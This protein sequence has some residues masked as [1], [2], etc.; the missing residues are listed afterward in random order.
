MAQKWPDDVPTVVMGTRW[1]ALT[2]GHLDSPILIET[3][4]LT[5]LTNR[6]IVAPHGPNHRS[7]PARHSPARALCRAPPRL[8]DRA[9]LIKPHWQGW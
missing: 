8:D 2:V 9:H 3:M 5:D 4:D 6:G 1:P 7:H